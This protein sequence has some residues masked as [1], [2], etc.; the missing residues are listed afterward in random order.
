MSSLSSPPQ[1]KT[2]TWVLVLLFWILAIAIFVAGYLVTNSKPQPTILTPTELQAQCTTAGFV[3]AATITNEGALIDCPEPVTEQL[4]YTNSFIAISFKYLSGWQLY[5]FTDGETGNSAIYLDNEPISDCDACSGG[6]NT[7]IAI[8]SRKLAKQED[9]L[10]PFG[11][12]IAQLNTSTAIEIT[13]QT[14]TTGTGLIAWT[15]NSPCIDLGCSTGKHEFWFKKIDG[16]L[17]SASFNDDT[18]TT[19]DN[20]AWSLFTSTVTQR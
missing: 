17:Y 14:E 5:S 10:D 4:S 6:I 16:W 9:G 3:D 12:K 15:D 20:D 18:T 11:A 13:K 1:N 7:P 19:A 8:T 2:H